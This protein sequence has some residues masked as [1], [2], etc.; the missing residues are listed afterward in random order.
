M[1]DISYNN[2]NSMSD[3]ALAEHIGR[4]VK[5]KR[6]EL[7]TTQDA[8]AHAAGISRSTL[9][10]LEKAETVTLSALLQVLRGA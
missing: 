9:G 3:T 4:F 8:L 10:L 1:T 6:M 5:E 2:W 7:N